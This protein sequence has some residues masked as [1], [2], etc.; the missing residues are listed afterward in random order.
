MYNGT[1]MSTI[2]TRKQNEKS[3]KTK[4]CRREKRIYKRQ[5][6]KDVEAKS[7]TPANKINFHLNRRKEEKI[8]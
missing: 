8:C 5:F 1:E 2:K 7:N 4:E 3:K 6:N